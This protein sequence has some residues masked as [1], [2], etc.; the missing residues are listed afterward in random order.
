MPATVPGATRSP[1]VRHS[2][3]RERTRTRDV[4]PLPRGV[5]GRGPRGGARVRRA[6]RRRTAA[7]WAALHEDGVPRPRRHRRVV[8]PDDRSVRPLRGGRRGGPRAPEGRRRTAQARRLPRRR[9]PARAG[10]RRLRDA[11]RAHR[12]AHRP[13]RGRR[14]G[15]DPR[16]PILNRSQ[17]R[18]FPP[19]RPGDL[20]PRTPTPEAN[21]ATDS[22]AEGKIVETRIPA[23][24]DRL[25]WARWHWMVLVG[26]GTVWI[27]DGLEVTIVGT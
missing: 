9:R 4:P 26:L 15:R 18:R 8:S 3:G 19:P 12:D 7:A 25:P 14:R 21:M 27:L 5:D 22:M 11:R 17:T 24:L 1:I 10:R 13:Q 2:D 16:P 23:R 6:G 20:H